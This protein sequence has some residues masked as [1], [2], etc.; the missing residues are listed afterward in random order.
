MN[1]EKD[2]HSTVDEREEEIVEIDQDMDMDME[3]DVEDQNMEGNGLRNIFEEY[4]HNFAWNDLQI[5]D[6][7]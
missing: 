7:H 6:M 3:M 1:K 4:D 2:T 5:Y